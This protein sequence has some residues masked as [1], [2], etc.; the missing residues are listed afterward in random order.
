MIAW[1][2]AKDDELL[3]DIDGRSG[4]PAKK[5]ES[6]RRRLR[7]AFL[8]KKLDVRSVWL[9]PSQTSK[10]FHAFVQLADNM[11]QVERIAWELRLG[12]DIYRTCANL[13]RH[14]RIIQAASLFFASDTEDE[15]I[16][17]SGF[18]RVADHYCTCTEHTEESLAHCV[19]EKWLRGRYA[20]CD[21]FGKVDRGEEVIPRLNIGKISLATITRKEPKT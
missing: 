7:A 20:S 3:I 5:L 8:C 4:E 9:F 13:L 10:H 1:Y 21:F 14:E 16:Q 6:F 2:V 12:S 19:I 11:R 18:Y 15:A 17:G